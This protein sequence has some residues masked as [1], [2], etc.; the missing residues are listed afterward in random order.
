MPIP[1]L[2]PSGLLPIGFFDCTLDEVSGNYTWSPR[3]IELWTAFSGFISWMK[4][5]PHISHLYIDGGFTSD[6]VHPKDID[7]VLDLTDSTPEV[8]LHW[9]SVFVTQKEKIASDFLVDFWVYHPS[10]PNDL[11][12]FFQYIRPEE[13]QARQLKPKDRKGMLRVSL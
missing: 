6:K 4:P 11:R 13:A 7:V 1:T 9:L 8:V 5:Q 2:L 12:K 3:R 10:M